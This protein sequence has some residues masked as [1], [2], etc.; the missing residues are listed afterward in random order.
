MIGLNIRD[1]SSIDLSLHDCSR[2]PRISSRMAFAAFVEI[3][4][5]KLAKSLPHRFFDFLGRNV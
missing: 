3:A 5:V 2:Q 1:K 4:G